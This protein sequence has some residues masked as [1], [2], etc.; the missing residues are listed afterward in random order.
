M[1]RKTAKARIRKL[2]ALMRDNGIDALL[3]TQPQ[4]VTYLSGF[5][6]EDSWL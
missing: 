5:L 2:H 4:N 1:D 3:V 6:G